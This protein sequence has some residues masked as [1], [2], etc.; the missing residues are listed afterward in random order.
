[1][2]SIRGETSLEIYEVF[3]RSFGG[4]A[5]G[6]TQNVEWF[7]VNRLW[8]TSVEDYEG[9]DLPFTGRKDGNVEQVHKILRK[10]WW[11]TL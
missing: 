11:S 7:P 2:L 10:D 4:Y 6:R 8:G 1:M 3:E 9:A 5:M